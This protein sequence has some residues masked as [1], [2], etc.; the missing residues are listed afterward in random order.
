MS[1][2]VSGLLHSLNATRLSFWISLLAKMLATATIVIAASVV[3]EHAGPFLGAMVATLP[4]SA[5]PAL[6]FLAVEHGPAFLQVSAQTGLAVFA[7][8]AILPRFTPGSHKG[9]AP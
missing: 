4:I 1:S 7:A 2:A 9:A 6:V 5:G 3:V 8:T